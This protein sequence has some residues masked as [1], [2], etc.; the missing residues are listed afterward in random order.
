MSVARL[1]ERYPFDIWNS[2]KVWLNGKVLHRV[3]SA[4]D[5]QR[6]DL[7]EV[8]TLNYAPAFQHA[9]GEFD[10][11]WFFIIEWALIRTYGADATVRSPLVRK[12]GPR[13]TNT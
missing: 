3:V 11:Q 8:Q 5:Q 12:S 9:V 10:G 6:W 13:H 1:L 2:I 4:V 7:N